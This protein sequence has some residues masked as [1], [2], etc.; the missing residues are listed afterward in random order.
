M[1]L[2]TWDKPR[3]T[4]CTEEFAQH[5]ALPRGCLQE[6]SDL[7]KGHG[8]RVPI[9]DEGHAGKPIE[10]KFQGDLRDDQAEA[11]RQTLRHDEGVL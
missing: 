3:V 11:I 5:L 2:P 9:R 10:V 4:S 1:R 8:I 6:V 7:L